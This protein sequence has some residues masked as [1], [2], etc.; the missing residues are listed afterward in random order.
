MTIESELWVSRYQVDKYLPD[1]FRRH[2]PS[3]RCVIDCTEIPIEKPTDPVLQRVTWSSYKN[4]NT[5][6]ALVAISPDGCLTF[7][8]KLYGGS[9]SDREITEACGLLDKLEAGDSVMADKGFTIGDL[10]EDRGVT[11]NIE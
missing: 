3:T 2:Y 6:K 1:E 10:L 8:S 5:L 4:R 9:V 11:L 7:V